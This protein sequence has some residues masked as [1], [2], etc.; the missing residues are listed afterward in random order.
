MNGGSVGMLAE[1]VDYVIG[2]DT[3]RDQH[4]LAV[5]A[6]P[7]GAVVAQRSVAAD[8]RGY[9]EA[10]RFADRFAR[11][12][13]AWAIEGAGHYGAGFTRFLASQGEAVVEVSRSVRAERRVRGQKNP[14]PPPPAAPP[15]PSV[16]VLAP[17]PGRGGAGGVGRVVP[18]RARARP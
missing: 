2:V 5:V 6:A 15:A 3:H 7:T 18:A 14:P 8:A 12:A 9:R 10:V 13:R 1:Q 16:L 4:A 17:P 11:G